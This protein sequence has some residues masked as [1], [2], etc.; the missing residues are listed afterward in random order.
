MHVF[1]EPGGCERTLQVADNLS[2]RPRPITALH[3][4]PGAP[5]ELHHPFRIQQNM[6][7]LCWLPLQPESPPHR[8]LGVSR[9]HAPLRGSGAAA[10]TG[11]TPYRK[12]IASFICHN[13]SSLN[14]NISNARCCAA[15]VLEK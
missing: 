9:N 11:S 15:R 3:D 6:R 10:D 14:C 8:G 7:L 5:I 13:T 12:A 4:L 1:F 2:D